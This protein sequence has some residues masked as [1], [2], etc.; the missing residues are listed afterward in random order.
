MSATITAAAA[1][2]SWSG[3]YVTNCH[4]VI[5]VRYHGPTNTLGS[6]WGAFY[7][8]DSETVWRSYVPF[9]DGPI[10]AAQKLI[11]DR[12]INLSVVSVG[13]IEPDA[14]AVL[15]AAS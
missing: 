6:R 14:Y 13:Q 4:S 12:E 15:C 7:R 8:R 1:A 3:A 2:P 10:A 11:A 5:G 9:A